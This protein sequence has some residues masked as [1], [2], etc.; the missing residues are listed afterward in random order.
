MVRL[1]YEWVVKAIV[2]SG[3]EFPASGKRTTVASA[4]FININDGLR[5]L[6]N[7]H[8]SIACIRIF[9]AYSAPSMNY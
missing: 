6:Y 2:Q 9:Y 4:N 8:T 5:A 1:V 3:R 7:G